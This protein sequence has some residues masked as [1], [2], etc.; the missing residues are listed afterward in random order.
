MDIRD[1]IEELRSKPEHVRERIALG[2]SIGITAL[3]FVGWLT[4][5]TTSGALVSQPTIADAHEAEQMSAAVEATKSSFSGLL[6][7]VGSIQPPAQNDGGLQIVDATTTTTFDTQS[8]PMEGKTV[9][10][11]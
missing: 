9:I 11:F 6:G 10:P 1:Y 7:A 8:D 4:A 2:S 5:L 3:V